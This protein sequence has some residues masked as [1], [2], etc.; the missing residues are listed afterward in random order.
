[1]PCSFYSLNFCE[2]G[3]FDVVVVDPPWDINM[4]LPYS[5][6]GDDLLLDLAFGNL[7]SQGVIFLWVTG[8]AM[9]KGRQCL[10]KWGYK[11]AEEIVWVKLNQYLVL[12]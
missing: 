12:G 4:S 1:M 2:L 5:T 6:L 11:K 3:Q 10:E 8:R 9:E 7:Q